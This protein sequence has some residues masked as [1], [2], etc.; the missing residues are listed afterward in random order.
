MSDRCDEV[1]IEE[2][3]PMRVASVRVISATPE[4]DAWARM[5]AWASARGLLNSAKNPIFGFNSP[6]PEPGQKIYGYEYWLRIDAATEIDGEAV[7][8]QFDGG[9]YAVSECRVSDPWKDIPSAWGRLLQWVL[10]NGYSVGSH[11]YFEVPEDPDAPDNRLVLRLY[12]P[13]TKT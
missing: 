10:K 7:E 6:D 13:V 8:R 2:L 5:K 12:C 11:Q 4:R 3:G 9:P 1:R